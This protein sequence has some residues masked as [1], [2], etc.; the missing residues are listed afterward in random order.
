AVSKYVELAVR[1]KEQ[2]NAGKWQE[3]TA[4]P[5][6][7]QISETYDVSRSTVRK[8]IQMMTEEGYLRSEQGSGTFVRPPN[9]RDS[10]RSL[11]SLSDDLDSK[12]CSAGQIILDLEI[13]EPSQFI[14]DKL[15]LDGTNERVQRVRRVRL[16]GTTPIGIHTAYIPLNGN[17]AITKEELIKSNSL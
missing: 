3:N 6:E 2:I 7:R 4:I 1:L 8:A 13:I 16:S 9:S 5:T 17:S 14:R 10:Q 12:G 15:S 11:H